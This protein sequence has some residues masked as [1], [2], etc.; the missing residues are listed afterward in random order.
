[1]MPCTGSA[2]FYNASLSAFPV[3]SFLWIKAPASTECCLKVLAELRTHYTQVHMD[4]EV[5][6]K[7]PSSGTKGKIV[8]FPKTWRKKS[9]PLAKTGVMKGI[10]HPC[11][12]CF[13]ECQKKSKSPLESGEHFQGHW[14]RTSEFSGTPTHC[15]IPLQVFTGHCQSN[16]WSGVIGKKSWFTSRGTSR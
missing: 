11:N 12:G 2:W 15:V 10:P 14:R 8:L 6:Q 3:L 4:F 16:L 1:M 13:L 5:S 7:G 9:F